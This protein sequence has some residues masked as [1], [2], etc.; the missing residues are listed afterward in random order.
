MVDANLIYVLTCIHDE[1]LF[2]ADLR[3]IR[4]LDTTSA[5]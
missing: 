5:I 3:H 1:S 2:Y 4:S